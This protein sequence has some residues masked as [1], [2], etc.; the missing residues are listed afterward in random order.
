MN[1]VLPIGATPLRPSAP[2]NTRVYAIGDIHGRSD[3][4]ARMLKTIAADAVYTH[5]RC[6]L[7]T[8]GDYVDRGPDSAEVL[9]QL[10]T[11]NA[12]PVFKNF[13]RYFLKG[14]HEHL[15][16]KF[17][18]GAGEDQAWDQAWLKSGG[19]E[20]LASYGAKF[21]ANSDAIDT[22]KQAERLIPKHHRQFLSALRLIHRE[23]DYI[24]AHAG[25]R[26]GVALAD[27]SAEDVMGIRAPFLNCDGE[28]GVVVVHGHSPG[29][30]PD[31][32]DNRIGIDTR[33]WVSGTLTAVVLEGR[34]QRFLST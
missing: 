7:V 6:V 17:L 26:P 3:L 15:M 33:A 22:L 30:R 13:E 14:N 8:L 18:H 28:L 12:H 1:A 19:R 5:L 25:V 9:E 10:S 23:G 34:Q 16:E 21:G 32:Q 27:Q 31:I 11:L 24:F 20:T 2:D 29:A 4:L